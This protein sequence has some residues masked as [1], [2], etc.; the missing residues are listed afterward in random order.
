MNRPLAKLLG[1]GKERARL[2]HHHFI[3]AWIRSPLKIGAFLPSSRALAR[4]MVEEVDIALPGAIIE[5]GAGTGAVTQ[6][7]LQAGIP[8]ERLVIIERDE[9]L[10]ALVHRHFPQLNVLCAD[11]ADMETVLAGAGVRKVSAIVSSL[12]L[13]SMPKPVR[14]AI[15]CQMALLIGEEGL[16]VQFTYGPRSPISRQQMRRHR[17][18]GKRMKLVVT[19]VPPAHVWVYRRG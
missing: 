12:P 19:N 11:A 4:A 14:T 7:L 2:R 1:K 17:L 13:L 10:H 15:E 3:A 5:L 18:H 9:K 16:I 8:P 6:A